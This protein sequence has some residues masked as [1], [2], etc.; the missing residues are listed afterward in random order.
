M[1]HAARVVIL[2]FAG[3]MV[4][5]SCGAGSAQRETPMSYEQVLKEKDIAEENPLVQ[6]SPE[7]TAALERFGD[8]FSAFTPEAMGEK[9]RRVYAE[10]VY[11]N[12]TLKEIRGVD[13]LEAYLVESA[14]AVEVG[15]V[16]VHDVARSGGNY[17]VRWVMELQFKKIQRGRM[18]RSTGISHL[19]F[20]AA[21]QVVYHQDYWDAASGLFEHIP[22]V[23]WM[24]RKIKGRL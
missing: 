11:F 15:R 23:G 14:E 18:T 24:I 3:L 21:G 2:A 20:N 13:A 10:D 9:V 7:E 12:D 17:Y 19:R 8:L 4:G 5:V 6:G 16:E 22:V 1:N